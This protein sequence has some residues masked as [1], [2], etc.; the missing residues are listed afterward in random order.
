MKQTLLFAL[1]AL[2]PFLAPAAGTATVR[3]TN[4]GTVPITVAGQTIR[5]SA[6]ASIAV[7]AG[8]AGA[9]ATATPNGSAA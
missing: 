9:F 6:T 1:L 3:V 7:P 4:S 2:L 8:E 5:P